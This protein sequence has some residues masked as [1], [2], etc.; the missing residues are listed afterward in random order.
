MTPLEGR[1]QDGF[2]TQFDTNHLARFLLF[3]LLRPALLAGVTRSL[4]LELSSWLQLL[5]AS[6]K[7]VSTTSILTATTMLWPRTPRERQRTFGL[8]MRSSAVMVHKGYTLGACNPAP[9]SWI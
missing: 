9:S 1:T 7:F 6:K 2:E 8:R 4:L 5:I 3:E